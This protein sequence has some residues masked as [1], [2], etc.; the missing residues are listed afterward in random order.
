MLNFNLFELWRLRDDV[1][2]ILRIIHGME[3][4]HNII[5]NISPNDVWLSQNRCKVVC[6][7]S[8]VAHLWREI[9]P[10][11]SF[12]HTIVYT[13]LY[14]IILLGG[15]IGGGGGFCRNFFLWCTVWCPFGEASETYGFSLFFRLNHRNCQQKNWLLA[16]NG[17]P[18]MGPG[19]ST[20]LDHSQALTASQDALHNYKRVFSH[21]W[22]ILSDNL[23]IS[24]GFPQL[25]WSNGQNSLFL[26]PHV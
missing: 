21:S 24:F 1:W 5:M 11:Y 14:Y 4:Y 25:R 18:D 7:T 9:Q 6:G 12:S 20:P 2:W 22:N 19:V 10:V 17:T 8:M 13:A 23:S 26:S 3:F 15:N 16:E